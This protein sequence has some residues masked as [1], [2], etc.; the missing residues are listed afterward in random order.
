M[1]EIGIRRTKKAKPLTF[2]T[3]DNCIIC[4]SH[5]E[6]ADGYVRIFAGIG[7]SPRMQLLHRIIWKFHK[8][9]IPKDCEIDHI[10]RNRRCCNIDHLQMLG[11]SE[12]KSKGNLLR[13]SDR[14]EKVKLAIINNVPIE[15][16]M[17][18]YSVPRNYVTRYIRNL[19]K[20]NAI[21]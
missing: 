5:T 11:R 2:T 16:I 15:E 9:E 20:Q 4:T 21:H 14:I 17:E 12:H 7:A 8:G 1:A 6:T 3:V 13:Y 10:C 18:R 19:K